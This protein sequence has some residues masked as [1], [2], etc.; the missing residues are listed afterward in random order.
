MSKNV[1]IKK[2]DEF[3]KHDKYVSLVKDYKIMEF[4]VDLVIGTSVFIN[5][6][7]MVKE[8]MQSILLATSYD[9]DRDTLCD[10]NN[11][12]QVILD[13]KDYGDFIVYDSAYGLFIKVFNKNDLSWIP[14]VYAY[15]DSWPGLLCEAPYTCPLNNSS[16]LKKCG[17]VYE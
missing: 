6:G 13:E 12:K 10:T 11:Y 16:E 8:V 1:Y 7:P 5:F 15:Y 3:F 9:S 17:V 14:L 2:V 4:T